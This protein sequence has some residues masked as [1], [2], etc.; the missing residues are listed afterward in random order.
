MLIIP[1]SKLISAYLSKFSIVDF[2]T[3]NISKKPIRDFKNSLTAISFAALSA[4]V[5]PLPRPLSNFF[6]PASIKSFCSISCSQIYWF[7]RI[8]FLC[9]RTFSSFQHNPNTGSGRGYTWIAPSLTLSKEVSK[10]YVFSK[11]GWYIVAFEVCEICT[12]IKR[13]R[14]RG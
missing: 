2:T 13:T 9:C 11:F 6:L 14:G 7:R 1:D 3:S 5:V 12:Y 4:Y 10:I 8:Y